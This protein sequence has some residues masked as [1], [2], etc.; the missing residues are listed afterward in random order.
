MRLRKP[1]MLEVKR[2][3]RGPQT[4]EAGVEADRWMAQAGSNRLIELERTDP[5]PN[6]RASH[7]QNVDM[8][9][10][11][12]HLP[13][14]VDAHDDAG[15]MQVGACREYPCDRRNPQQQFAAQEHAGD[16]QDQRQR[17]AYWELAPTGQVLRTENR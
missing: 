8:A 9:V 10:L 2:D 17:A 7:E 15:F 4:R 5:A 3:S 6:D 16:R 12:H 14:R 13:E 1:E 11:S